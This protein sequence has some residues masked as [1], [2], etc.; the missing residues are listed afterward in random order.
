MIST[1]VFH[2]AFTVNGTARQALIDDP[3]WRWGNR[4]LGDPLMRADG[5][6]AVIG[7]YGQG[8]SRLVASLRDPR[9][10]A[11]IRMRA[12]QKAGV[13]QM[14]LADLREREMPELEVEAEAEL[15]AQMAFVQAFTDPDEN[16]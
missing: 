16:A 14:Q 1:E 13:L 2:P 4:V 6:G 8:L 11:E 9:T 5:K 12:E 10:R 3:N 7:A 15:H